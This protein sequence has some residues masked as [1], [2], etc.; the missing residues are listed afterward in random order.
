MTLIS[1]WEY[2]CD[3]QNCKQVNFMSSEEY[4][5]AVG[6]EMI[7]CRVRHYPQDPPDTRHFCS[8]ECLLKF[9]RQYPSAL[10]ELERN[11]K[12]IFAS[13]ARAGRTT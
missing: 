1:A 5:D 11:A 6:S 2:C 8:S 3:A 9:Q 4:E 13:T 7:E 12:D 10:I